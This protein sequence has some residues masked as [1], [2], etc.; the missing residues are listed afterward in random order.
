MNHEAVEAMRCLRMGAIESPLVS[1]RDT[2]DVMT[3]LD[4]VR[5]Q[6]G[7]RYPGEAV[8]E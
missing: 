7:V 8:E 6:I 2:L 3:L 1:W 5:E 4:G